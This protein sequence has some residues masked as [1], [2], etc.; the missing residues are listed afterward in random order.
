[1]AESTNQPERQPGEVAASTAAPAQPT[2]GDHHTSRVA[3]LLI[4]IV[5]VVGVVTYLGPIL[6]PFLVAVFLFFATKAAAGVF[7]R[8]RFPPLLAYLLLFVFGSAA[9]AG[10]ALLAYG[11]VLALRDEWPS[12]QGR[13]QAAIGKVPDEVRQPLSDLIRK[14]SRQA[15]EHVFGRAFGVLELLVMAFF[16]LLFILLG[17]SQLPQRVRR[18]FPDGRGER[19]IVLAGK[20]GDGMERFMQ[21]K[22]LVSLGL[23]ASAALLAY[24]FGLQGW[25]L[26]GVLFFAL[27]YVTYV[28]SI[29][30]CVPPVALAFLVWPDSPVKA[31][32]L[33]VL[34]VLNRFVWID[35]VEVR[36]AGHQLNINSILL[37]LWLAYWGWVWGGIGLI[38]AFPM[39]TGL[40][41]VLENLEATKGWAVLMSEE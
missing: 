36:V 22:T 39:V 8:R 32:A 30:A 14:S 28:G 31:V 23:G 12:H 21:V 40:K 26:W 35:Y 6:K 18:A 11:E 33:S 29:A 7:I 25:L 37:F 24:L 27:N 17:A 1:V 5:V 34:I 20:I 13:I 9:V 19:L 16:Y 4:A 10:L 3:L 38:L 41:I 15:F 2:G